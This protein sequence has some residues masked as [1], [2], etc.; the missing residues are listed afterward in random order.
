[1]YW[2]LPLSVYVRAAV[3]I[4]STFAAALSWKYIESPFRSTH[5][6]ISRRTIYFGAA[7][8]SVLFLVVGV[9][10]YVGEGFPRR[11]PGYAHLQYRDRLAEYNE[12]SCF[13]MSDQELSDW[14]GG[15]CLLSKR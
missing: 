1:Y 4:F 2:I 11:Y 10:G 14:E 3:L 6:R 13:L 15:Q 8:A 9:V 7:V 12:R 5:G